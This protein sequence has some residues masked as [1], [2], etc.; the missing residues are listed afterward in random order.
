MARDDTNDDL[1]ALR[2]LAWTLEEPARAT[3]L[4]DLTGLDAPALRASA[5]SPATLAATLAFLENHE[6]DLI[7]CAEAIGFPPGALVALRAR[8]EGAA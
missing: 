5:G 8:L 2:A 6:A 4:L 1:L 3:R 7:A